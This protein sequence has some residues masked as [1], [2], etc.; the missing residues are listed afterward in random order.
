M[1]D[2]GTKPPNMSHF[3]SEWACW[4]LQAPAQLSEKL[5]SATQHPIRAGIW[6]DSSDS[7][8]SRGPMYRIQW[9]VVAQANLCTTLRLEE[10]EDHDAPT[11][12]LRPRSDSRHISWHRKKRGIRLVSRRAPQHSQCRVH[13][14]VT[15]MVSVALVFCASSPPLICENANILP[16]HC[17]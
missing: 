2:T 14:H 3:N 11:S 1:S 16:M 6:R 13:V 9:W 15:A 10:G 4:Q 8:V 7:A 5:D 12:E 17:W